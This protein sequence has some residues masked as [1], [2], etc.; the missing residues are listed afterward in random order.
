MRNPN[1]FVF[2]VEDDDNNIVSINNTLD[3][4][5]MYFNRMHYIWF[6]PN[7]I[8]N[9]QELSVYEKVEDG[10]SE[11]EYIQNYS[12]SYIVSENEVGP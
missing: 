5:L 4:A 2:I 6:Q 12:A 9:L 7:I 8:N 11:D 3:G 1:R 10:T